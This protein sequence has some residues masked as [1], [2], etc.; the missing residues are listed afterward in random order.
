MKL[1]HLFLNFL[2]GSKL[3]LLLILKAAIGAKKY[4]KTGNKAT[5]LFRVEDV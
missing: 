3:S 1:L 4:P 2:I 5:S